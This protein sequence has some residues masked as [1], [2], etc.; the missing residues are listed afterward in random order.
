MRNFQLIGRGLDVTPLHHALVRQPELWNAETFRTT[1]KHTP[2]A[3]VDDIIIRY[4]APEALNRDDTSAVQNDH[5]A[6]WYPA[7]QSLPE[8]K[9]IV[10]NLMAYMGA[11]ELARCVISRLKPGGR[12]LPHAD[13]VGD[14][15]HM[16]DIARYHIVVQGLPGSMYRCGDEEVCMQT[17]ETWWFNAHLE[18]EIYNNSKDDR[19]HLMADLRK[20]P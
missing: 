6:V 8:V 20:W 12:I 9:P 7:A 16:G 2:H 5:G 4:S 14:Y 18:H 15:V 10:L 19:L 3:D 13:A 1:Y 17:G 11:Y